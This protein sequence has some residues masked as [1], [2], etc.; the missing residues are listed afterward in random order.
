MAA[1]RDKT[2]QERLKQFFKFS[3]TG[4]QHQTSGAQP[5][6]R[7]KVEKFILTKEIQH[8]LAQDT[9]VPLRLKHLQDV[10]EQISIK[11]IE[12]DGAETLWLL[13][14]DLFTFD[15]I[16]ER[17]TALMFLKSLIIGQYERLGMLRV[18]IFEIIKDSPYKED[19]SILIELLKAVT[20]NGK[21]LLYLEETIGDFLL[22]FLPQV[23]QQNLLKAFLPCLLNVLKFNSAY[24]DSNVL[25]SIVNNLC[26]LAITST[27]SEEVLRIIDVFDVVICY[28]NLPNESLIVFTSTLCRLV[29]VSSYSNLS[30]KVLRN[31]VGTHLGTSTLYTIIH[32]LQSSEDASL[33]RGGIFF[34]GMVL[35]SDRPPNCPLLPPVIVLPSLNESLKNTSN[36]LVIFEAGL[37]LQKLVKFDGPNLVGLA[38]DWVL[39][40]MDRLF[41]FG[42]EYPKILDVYLEV[43]N[44]VHQLVE[45]GAY[46]GSLDLFFDAVEHAIQHVEEPLIVSSIDFQLKKLTPSC[47]N[48]IGSLGKLVQR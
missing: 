25:G 6:G 11:R 44:E 2:F 5:F 29:N 19:T 21:D 48:W 16:E 38:W 45:S 24:L 14:H 34:I 26:N 10:G 31:L 12:D 18:Y 1:N 7:L 43:L 22:N 27:D 39:E 20:D 23:S 4:A 8:Q 28:S 17:Q 37:A 3:K 32:S 35:W 46:A 9:P 41:T 33:L 40:M 15:G 36:P 30:W 13:V 47:A 42:I